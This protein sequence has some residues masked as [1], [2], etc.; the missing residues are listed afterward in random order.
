MPYCTTVY[1]VSGTI[2][3]MF[4]AMCYARTSCIQEE[5]DDLQINHFAR[6]I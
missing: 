6:M 3:G 5:N 4:D 1:H 2:S